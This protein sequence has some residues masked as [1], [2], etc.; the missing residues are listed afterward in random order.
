[1][2]K[3]RKSNLLA[4]Q[5]VNPAGNPPIYNSVRSRDVPGNQTMFGSG[6]KPDAFMNP[7]AQSGVRAVAY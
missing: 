6:Y 1:M 5:V 7:V 2:D 3:A 4:V